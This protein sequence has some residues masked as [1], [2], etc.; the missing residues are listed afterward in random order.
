MDGMDT[1]SIKKNALSQGGLTRVNMSTDADIPNI[2]NVLLHFSISFRYYGL[3]LKVK[4]T[5]HPCKR[6][7]KEALKQLFKRQNQGGRS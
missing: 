6:G 7:L 1:I 5:Y 4:T 2:L 3:T